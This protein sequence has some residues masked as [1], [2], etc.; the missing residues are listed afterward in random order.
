MGFDSNSSPHLIHS[1]QTRRGARCLFLYMQNKGFG[2]RVLPVP[3]DRASL[4]AGSASG[5]PWASSFFPEDPLRGRLAPR[6]RSAAGG[7]ADDAG[8][9]AAVA[10]AVAV[11]VAVVEAGVG[12]ARELGM[13]SK[14]DSAVAD[15]V[16][17][18][19]ARR[20]RWACPDVRRVIKPHQESQASA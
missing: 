11:V 14:I 17:E 10:V 5:L 12:A 16:E 7:G 15:V 3:G 6:L 4:L 2:P 20:L 18:V 19:G 1:C 13:R 8:L 9:V